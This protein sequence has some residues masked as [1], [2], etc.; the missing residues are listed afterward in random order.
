MS[1]TQQRHL[2]HA[3]LMVGVKRPAPSE[4]T[5]PSKVHD[6]KHHQEEDFPRGGGG[7]LTALQRRELREEG[8]AEAE[9]EF[10]AGGGG[11]DG[12]RKRRKTSEVAGRFVLGHNTQSSLAC[13]LMSWKLLWPGRETDHQNLAAYITLK[14]TNAAG[15]AWSLN[16]C[17]YSIMTLMWLCLAG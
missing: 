3:D 5:A 17:K 1:I 15:F 11:G 13:I 16:D 9:R 2:Y 7:G 4:A 8:A 14:I 6:N 12:A 10:A